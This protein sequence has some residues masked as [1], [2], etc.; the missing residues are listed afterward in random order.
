MVSSGDGGIIAAAGACSGDG[1][2]GSS[3]SVRIARRSLAA[4]PGC[5]A[6]M[7]PP[8]MDSLCRPSSF[9]GDGAA[10]AP[11][12]PATKIIA[13]LGALAVLSLAGAARRPC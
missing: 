1:G 12:P 4:K 9:P 6:I 2:A 10:G 11:P 7:A 8:T 3:S 13:T 5:A